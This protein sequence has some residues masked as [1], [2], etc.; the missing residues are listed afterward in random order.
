METKINNSFPTAQL[1]WP[2]YHKPYRL[3]IPDRRGGLLVYIKPYLPSRSLTGYTTYIQIIPFELNLRKERWILMCI[4]RPPAQNKQYFLE[5]LSM[6]V[7][8]YLSIYD[9]HIFLG[10][11]NIQPNSPNYYHLCS[12]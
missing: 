6:V 11:F 7:D 4:Y 1:S 5:N 8:H 9:N 12:L 10:D 2:V 3:D